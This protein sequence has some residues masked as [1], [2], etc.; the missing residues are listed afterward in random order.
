M[1]DYTHLRRPAHILPPVSGH[2]TSDGAGDGDVGPKLSLTKSG[3]ARWSP[4]KLEPVF[5]SHFTTTY[6]I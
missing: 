2:V 1:H 4:G 6:S 5:A 3:E